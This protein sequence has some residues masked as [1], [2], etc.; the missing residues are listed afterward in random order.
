MNPGVELRSIS[1]EATPEEVA[2][3][4]AAVTQVERE[5][6]AQAAAASTVDSQRLDHWRLA[7]RLAHRRTGMTRGPWRLSGRLARR[8]RA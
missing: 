2:A 4:V 7:P 8:V 3:I 5:L 6:A 1:P